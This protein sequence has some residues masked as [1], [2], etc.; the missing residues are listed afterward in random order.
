VH[1][2]GLFLHEYIEMYSQQNIKKKGRKIF[3]AVY[4][5]TA[6]EGAETA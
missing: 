5:R 6:V 2:V 4:E 3:S 1:Q